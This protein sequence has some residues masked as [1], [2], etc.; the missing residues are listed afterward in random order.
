MFLIS[1][2]FVQNI[3]IIYFVISIFLSFFW[4]AP[5]SQN[6][7]LIS[8]MFKNKVIV[9][10]FILMG[11]YQLYLN[12]RP[13]KYDDNEFSFFS[14]Y[15]WSI[16]FFNGWQK[17]KSVWPTFQICGY[18]KKYENSIWMYFVQ[19]DHKGLNLYCLKCKIQ[20]FLLCLWTLM[21]FRLVYILHIC[22][23]V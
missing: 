9:I 21:V 17:R 22:G 15:F 11:I 3:E 18:R 4:N 16:L 10:I 13:I 7:I 2:K 8:K 12:M 1:R 5:I 6:S 14:V 19:I 20:N 23:S